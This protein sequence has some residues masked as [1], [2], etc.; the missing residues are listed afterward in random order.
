MD[1]LV[2]S[3]GAIRAAQFG[4]KRIVMMLLVSRELFLEAALT[5]TN[6]MKFT[7]TSKY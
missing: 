4:Y 1:L 3:I 7:C 2:G 6:F 5:S